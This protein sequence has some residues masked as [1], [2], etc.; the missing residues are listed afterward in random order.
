MAIT[1]GTLVPR[2]SRGPRVVKARCEHT[3]L[4]TRRATLWLWSCSWAF[5]PKCSI[6]LSLNL[7]RE[8]ALLAQFLVHYWANLEVHHHP[9]VHV[10]KRGLRALDVDDET[11]S[12][13]P[14]ASPLNNPAGRRG[15][16]LEGIYGYTRYGFPST[17]GDQLIQ[18]NRDD[19]NSGSPLGS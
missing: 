3:L 5:H 17:L 15:G 9:P 6:L 7:K 4:P 2:I 11:W 13:Y 10:G 12:S 1:M 19:G 16:R 8:E 18:R 14:I